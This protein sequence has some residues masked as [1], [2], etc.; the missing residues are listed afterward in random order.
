[1]P[2]LAPSVELVRHHKLL[3]FQLFDLLFVGRDHKDPAFFSYSDNYLID[4]GHGVI[5]DV[6]TAR[7][8]RQAEVGSTKTPRSK[9]TPA[10][11]KWVPGR[12]WKGRPL[13]AASVA[14]RKD[15]DHVWRISVPRTLRHSRMKAASAVQPFAET[16][17]PST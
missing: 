12:N 9:P 15:R 6:D 5:V 3:G 7:S 2:R 11:S 8:V 13:F 1:M 10:P 16:I 14:V 17:L 4:T